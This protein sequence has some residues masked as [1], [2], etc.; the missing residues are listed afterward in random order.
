MKASALRSARRCSAVVPVA[1]TGARYWHVPTAEPGEAARTAAAPDAWLR[2]TWCMAA[3]NVSGLRMP[4]ACTPM[5][6]PTVTK[7]SGSLNTIQFRT[8]SPSASAT[9]AA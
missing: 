7:L 5:R 1:R 3:R 4:G 9:S 2:F 8:R 6:C